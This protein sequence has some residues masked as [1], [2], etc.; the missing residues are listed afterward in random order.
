MY[1]H[2]FTKT[3]TNKAHSKIQMERLYRLKISGKP[4]ECY[5][6]KQYSCF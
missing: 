1:N 2:C 6:F 5:V 4:T 3:K